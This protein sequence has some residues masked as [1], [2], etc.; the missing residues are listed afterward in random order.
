MITMTTKERTTVTVT[1]KGTTTTTQLAAQAIIKPE[2]TNNRKRQ[3]KHLFSNRSS[4]YNK[5]NGNTKIYMFSRN[6]M[7]P[8]PHDWARSAHINGN[9]DRV[10]SNKSDCQKDKLGWMG[11][12]ILLRC[13]AYHKHRRFNISAKQKISLSDTE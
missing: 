10:S 7:Y 11:E 8:L 5:Q 3:T 4:I 9:H 2:W 1:K 13:H 12:K 6:S